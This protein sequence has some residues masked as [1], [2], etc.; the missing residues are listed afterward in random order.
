MSYTFATVNEAELGPEDLVALRADLHAE[1]AF[2]LE[3]LAGIWPSR[4]DLP[5]DQHARQ[6]VLTALAAAARVV[7]TDVSAALRR[8]DAGQYGCCH[9]CDRPIP[10]ACLRILPH[11]RYCGPCHQLKEAVS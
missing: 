5:A 2:R 10:L 6:E 7:L 3:Q 8:M 11:A 4:D 1:R 9:L